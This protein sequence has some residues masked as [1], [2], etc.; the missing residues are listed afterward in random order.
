MTELPDRSKAY[1]AIVTYLTTLD[2]DRDRLEAL[3]AIGDAMCFFCGII[4]HGCPVSARI[5]AS[6]SELCSRDG[7]LQNDAP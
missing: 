5:V 7:Q 3:T 4:E 6:R 2:T 1:E